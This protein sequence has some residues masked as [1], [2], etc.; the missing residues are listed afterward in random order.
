M[1][2]LIDKRSLTFRLMNNEDKKKFVE[3]YKLLQY[4][5]NRHFQNKKNKMKKYSGRV[6]KFEEDGNNTKPIIIE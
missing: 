1:K 6:I 2:Q 4:E 5:R 3:K